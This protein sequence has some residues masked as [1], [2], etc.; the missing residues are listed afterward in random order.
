MAKTILTISLTVYFLFGLHCVGET[1]GGAGLYLPNNIIGWA[2]IATFIGVGFWHLSR[3]GIIYYSTFSLFCAM[4]LLLIAVPMYYNNNLFAERAIYRL[5]FIAGGILFYFIMLQ[6]DFN[7]KE[8]KNLMFII[9]AA[10]V[11]QSIIG[12]IQS[13][14]LG[15]QQYI[16]FFKEEFPWG[17][18][19]QKNVMTT[20]MATGIGISLYFL[21]DYE[22][23]CCLNFLV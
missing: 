4:A 21:N 10:T 6:F 2:F 12:V 17:S 7:D 1:V 15:P 3:T 18:F 19:R 8:R 16:I 5:M 13:Y 23:R 20:F 14:G 22:F 9:L 11:I